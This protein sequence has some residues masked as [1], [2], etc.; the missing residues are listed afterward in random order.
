[1]ICVKVLRLF[2][3]NKRSPDQ[4]FRAFSLLLFTLMTRSPLVVGCEFAC[5]RKKSTANSH[6]R[7]KAAIIFSRGLGS[8]CD[9]LL[10]FIE[11]CLKTAFSRG[12]Q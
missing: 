8:R 2:G 7:F 6:T 10:N 1:M 4:L 12:S 11:K 5:N 9:V 3:N